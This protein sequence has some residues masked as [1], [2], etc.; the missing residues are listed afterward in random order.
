MSDKEY[1]EIYET[2]KKNSIGE[3]KKSSA[4]KMTSNTAIKIAAGVLIT[5]LATAGIIALFAPKKDK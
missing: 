5:V 4:K 3:D 1:E 2:T